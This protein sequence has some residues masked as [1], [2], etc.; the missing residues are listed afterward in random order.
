MTENDNEIV[1][2]K[3]MLKDLA[4]YAGD[5][6]CGGNKCRLPHSLSFLQHGFREPGAQ[7]G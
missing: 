7:A 2:L 4:R 5:A 1:E 3:Q 6:E